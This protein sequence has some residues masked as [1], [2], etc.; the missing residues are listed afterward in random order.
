MLF[1]FLLIFVK[2]MGDKEYCKDGLPVRKLE[3]LKLNNEINIRI[4]V[5]R[6]G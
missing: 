5:N 3:Q 2:S 4:R 6:I 1:C